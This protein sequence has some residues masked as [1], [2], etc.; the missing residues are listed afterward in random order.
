MVSLKQKYN[1]NFVESGIQEKWSSTKLYTW[2]DKQNNFVI[3][4]PPPTISGL[5]HIG[6]IFSY[7]HTDFI[8]RYQ[9]MKG[10][11]VFYPMGFDDNGLPTER[12]VEKKHK[13][14]A[15]KTD[16]AKFVKLCHEVSKSDRERF[17]TLFQ[18]IGLSIDWDLEYHTISDKCMALSQMSFLDLYEKNEIYRQEQP[19]FWD[20]IDQTAIAQAE[21]EEKEF[22]SYMNYITFK[23]TDEQRFTIATTRPELLPACVAILVHPEDKRYQHL[24]NSTA[25]TPLFSISVPIIADKNVKIDKGS[26]A[27]MCC[28]FGDEMDIQWWRSHSLKTKI[29]INKYGKIDNLSE[30]ISDEK[31]ISTLQGLKIKDARIKII[32][33]LADYITKREEITHNVKCAERSGSPLEILPTKQWFVK[34]LLH[35][36]KLLHAAKE[37]NWYPANRQTTIENWIE[38]LKW[39]WCISR[40]RYFGIHFPVWYSKRANEEGK[41]LVAQPSQLP[42]DPTIDLPEGY[43]RDEVIAETDIMD[44]WATSSITPQL[45][46]KFINNKY[47]IENHHSILPADL[48]PQA[49]EIIRTWAF[50][51]IV[52]SKLHSDSIPW[53]NLMISGWCLAE[54]KSKMSK[55][56]GNVIEPHTLIEQYGADVIR[57]WASNSRLGHDTVYSENIMKMGKRLIT[58]IWNAAKFIENFVTH[59]FTKTAISSPIDLWIAGEAENTLSKVT[60]KLDGFEYCEA[61]EHLENFF[62]KDYCDNYLELVKSRA[63]NK[64]IE[65]HNSAI[66]CLSYTFELILKMFAPFIPFITEEIYN[67]LYSS[68]SI[69][70]K[71][72]WPNV[73]GKI[74]SKYHLIGNAAINILSEIRMRKSSDK[75][76]IKK[77]INITIRTNYTNLDE[78]QHDLK[79]ATNTEELKLQKYDNATNNDEIIA[80]I[81]EYNYV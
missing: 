1:A 5:L 37:C 20:P 6:H 22:S 65:H 40:Q 39:D 75:V 26:G 44:T 58:K 78:I 54:D 55:S 46:A 12:L 61:R 34:V 29:I 38:N 62:W 15:H 73:T 8:A 53:R 66:N 30:F 77:P 43:S 71:N 64:E 7:C 57:Y 21:T 45:N 80:E 9:R 27:V 2:L 48:R 31:L 17:R 3:D 32:E 68:H 52:K 47:H 67:N 13:I 81:I 4:T 19:M 14:R 69:H 50:Y 10:K 51:T 72:S 56:K 24:I 36:K 11:D 25:V 79:C 59:D 42:V 41:V 28:T 60:K 70:R 23:T 16:K 63:Y 74:D 33:L 35:K 18:R 76:S 49:H